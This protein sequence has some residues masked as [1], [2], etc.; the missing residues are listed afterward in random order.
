MELRETADKNIKQI[1]YS[2]LTYIEII[3]IYYS[4]TI[5]RYEE[6]NVFLSY[7]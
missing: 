4:I 3:N 6:S 7:L 1:V 5:I 2:Q